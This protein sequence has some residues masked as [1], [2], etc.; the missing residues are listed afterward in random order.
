MWGLSRGAQGKIQ[1]H[2]WADPN[3]WR[4]V[5]LT[6]G[7]Q[8]PVDFLHH[9]TVQGPLDRVS[10]TFPPLLGKLYGHI[11]ECQLSLGQ[12]HSSLFS[13][14]LSSLPVFLQVTWICGNQWSQ[15]SV[16]LRFSFFSGSSFPCWGV[17]IES[18]RM[19]HFTKL[20]WEGLSWVSRTVVAVLWSGGLGEPNSQGF[21]L[22]IPS[23]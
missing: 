22:I 14:P 11:P 23:L 17:V 7:D 21:F 13:F 20:P 9:P 2:S 8:V 15:G 3:F 12:S 10:R 16:L 18:H 1:R 19:N 4:E 6:Q 5:I